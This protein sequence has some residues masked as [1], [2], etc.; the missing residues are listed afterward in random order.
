MERLSGLIRLRRKTEKEKKKGEEQGKVFAC[1]F[2][3][4][5][6][7]EAMGLGSNSKEQRSQ[8]RMLLIVITS[9]KPTDSHR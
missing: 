8:L 2:V 4:D 5:I 3:E 1:S 9:K 7:E 6:V